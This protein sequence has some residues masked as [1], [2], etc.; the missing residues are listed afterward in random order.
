M[1][2][3]GSYTTIEQSKKLAEILLLESA[4]MYYYCGDVNK[5]TI[6]RG[7]YKDVKDWFLDGRTRVADIPCWSFS[8]LID[9]IENIDKQQKVE[10]SFTHSGGKYWVN[11][12]FDEFGS[13]CQD[14]ELY[15]SKVD[16]CVAMIEKLK[17]R[18]LL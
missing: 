13:F 11:V 2:T 1:A 5:I 3:I 14:Y 10:V 18:N 15:D 7:I 12:H 4:D 8:T 16:A 17:D 6:G 9:I